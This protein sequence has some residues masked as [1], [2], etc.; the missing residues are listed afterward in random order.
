VF[1]LVRA[2]DGDT[3]R[4]VH[5]VRFEEIAHVLHAFQ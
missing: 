1:E 3:Y 5:R 4:A 2:N